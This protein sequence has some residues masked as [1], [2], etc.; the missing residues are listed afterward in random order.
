MLRFLFKAFDPLPPALVVILILN[1][2]EVVKGCNLQKVFI[3][4]LKLFQ[5]P[6]V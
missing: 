5:R 2:R 1:Y 3:A 4:F 6:N